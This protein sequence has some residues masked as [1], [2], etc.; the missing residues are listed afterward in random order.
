MDDGA[1]SGRSRS[2]NVEDGK[3]AI[4]ILIK[5]LRRQVSRNRIGVIALFKYLNCLVLTYVFDAALVTRQNH[6][7]P[8]F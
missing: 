4:D 5:Q 1:E 6:F 7:N 3:T 8:M 2:G